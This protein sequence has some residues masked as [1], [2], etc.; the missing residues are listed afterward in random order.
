M[1]ATLVALVLALAFSPVA[2]A[3]GRAAA[4]LD[5]KREQACPSTG[6]ITGPCPSYVIDYI[7]PLACGGAEAPY[8]LQWQT[9]AAGKAKRKRE[10][11]GCT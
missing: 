8:N 5:F 6:K 1:K 7:K 2:F 4:E 9:L 10:R 3:K 11:A